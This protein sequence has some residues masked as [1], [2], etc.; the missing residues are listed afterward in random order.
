M[1]PSAGVGFR[2]WSVAAAVSTL[3]DA[4]TYFALGWAGAAHG[5]AT[6]SLVL[7]LQSVPLCVLILAGGMLADGFGVRR[8]MLA[9]DAAMVLV[10]AAFLLHSLGGASVLALCL[11]AVAAGTS[12]ALRR[13]A[14]GAFPRLFVDDD[15]LAQAMAQVS[16]LQQL[17]RTSGPALGGVLLG[18]GGLSLVA[19]LDLV[20]FVLVLAVLAAV[21]PPR[22]QVAPEPERVLRGVTRSVRAAYDVGVGPLLGAIV[23][24]AAS[25]LVAVILGVPLVGQ[26]RGWG[27]A[28]TGVVAGCWTVGTFTVTAVVARRG[29]PGPWS[30]IGGPVMGAAG[31]AVLAFAGS[32]WLSAIGLLLLGVGTASYTCTVLP[33]FVQASPPAM[34]GRFQAL[35][36]FAQNLAIL[37]ALP[38]FGWLAAAAS[39]AT[40]LWVMAGLLLI[41][42]CFPWPDVRAPHAAHAEPEV[43]DRTPAV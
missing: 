5:P 29:T 30:R 42:A 27:A 4:V 13:P 21:R 2:T 25:V 7:T 28:A 40:A 16:L 9:C 20:T 39:P 43:I 37:I 10:T 3:G 12:A 1:R 34:I 41:T 6:A 33:L 32:T 35:L 8:T 14:D 17:A 18:M 19:G 23:L 24:L 15:G 11:L 38:S 31:I 22:A 26:E 36:G